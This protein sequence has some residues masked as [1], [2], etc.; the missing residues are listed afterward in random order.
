MIYNRTLGYFGTARNDN[1]V[2]RLWKSNKHE[3]EKLS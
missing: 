1:S 3:R 2:E